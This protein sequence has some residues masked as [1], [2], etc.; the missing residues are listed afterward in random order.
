M[1]EFSEVFKFWS[2]CVYSLD[3]ESHSPLTQSSWSL[4]LHWLSPH[5][6][7]LFID[8]VLMESRSPL[9][10]SSWSLTV[11]WLSPHG[12]SLSIDSVLMESHSPL[13]RY[14]WSL[15]L[16]WLSPQGVSLSIDSV[17]GKWASTSAE[18]T[19]KDQ[20]FI[21]CISANSRIKS[22]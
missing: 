16:H 5:G 8:S 20:N 10:Q 4:T 13:T 15:T 6:V 9:T 11:Y 17:D 14:S 19:W 7:S 3:I 1:P 22:K 12:V 21:Y 18:S 2:S